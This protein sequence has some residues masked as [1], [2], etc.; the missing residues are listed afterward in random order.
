MLR[1][2]RAEGS[3]DFLSG[4]DVVVEGEELVKPVPILV[5]G[6]RK[7]S[8]SDNDRVVHFH[9]EQAG[10]PRAARGGS[11]IC[12]I[13]TAKGRPMSGVREARSHCPI[14][15]P[16]TVEWVNTGRRAKLLALCKGVRLLHQDLRT[17]EVQDLFVWQVL[18]DRMED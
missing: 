14:F 18:L 8:L 11:P 6:D 13:S 4:T 10:Q 7:P 3:S 9:R 17:R 5:D 16:D 12:D 2:A 15:Y 1:K